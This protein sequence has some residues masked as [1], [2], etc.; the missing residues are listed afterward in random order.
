MSAKVAEAVK[1]Q[2]ALLAASPAYREQSGV[3]SAE[4]AKLCANVL[5]RIG[6]LEGFDPTGNIWYK[7]KT[8]LEANA[9]DEFFTYTLDDAGTA[10]IARRYYSANTPSDAC[11]FGMGDE[12]TITD[13]FHSEI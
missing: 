3:T 6:G 7:N 10:H 5:K 1:A 9:G 2:T 8:K 13:I 11:P 12:D 4:A